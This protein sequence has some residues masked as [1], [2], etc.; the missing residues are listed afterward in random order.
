VDPLSAIIGFVG[1]GERAGFGT[2]FPV[3]TSTCGEFSF[4]NR[5]ELD[6]K[7]ISIPTPEPSTYNGPES[8][9]DR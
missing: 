4:I 9:A 2:Q 1:P 5:I 8:A 7:E 6:G 3:T